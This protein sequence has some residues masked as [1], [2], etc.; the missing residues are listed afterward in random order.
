MYQG[1]GRPAKPPWP[2]VTVWRHALV[3]EAWAHLTVRDGEKGPVGIEMVTRR[4][5]TRLER[6]RTGD[7]KSGWW[8]RVVPSWMR[9]RWRGG[10]ARMPATRMPAMGIATIWLTD[11]CGQRST[12]GTVAG[13]TGASHQSGNMS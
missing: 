10:I 1:R 13:G 2:S 11:V 6:K 7:P 9:I 8:S 5:Q 12:G 4:V 3:P